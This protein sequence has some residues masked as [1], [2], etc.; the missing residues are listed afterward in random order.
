MAIEGINSGRAG[1][2]GSTGDMRSL[3][4]RKM[5]RASLL[6]PGGS[7]N[8]QWER[9]GIVRAEISITMHQST[10]VTL[11][12]RS[13]SH[14]GEWQDKRYEVMVDWTAC[15]FG[16]TR[17]WW[18]CPCC[19]QRVAVLWGGTTYACRHCQKINYE[20]TRRAESDKP[21]DR[22]NKLRKRLGWVPGVAHGMGEQ[23]KGMHM[24][25]YLRLLQQY[26]V[27]AQATLQSTD[28]LLARLKRTIGP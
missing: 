7:F 3:D 17:P 5:H 13:R 14:G 26:T 9:G 28:K 8:W 12:Y 16:G 10:S 2:K 27:Q 22:A 19:G 21:F 24:T 6:K 11:N 4:I 20:S 25:T 1:T 23:P 18:N 15:H